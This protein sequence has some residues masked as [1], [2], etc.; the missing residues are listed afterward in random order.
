MKKDKKG[1]ECKNGYGNC[2]KDD[3][4]IGGS[5]KLIDDIPKY[6][7]NHLKTHQEEL[8]KVL[9]MSPQEIHTIKTI[10]R[11]LLGEKTILGDIKGDL[12]GGSLNKQHLKDLA[13]INNVNDLADMVEEDHK[14]VGGG[15][16]QPSFSHS[17]YQLNE[18][19]GVMNLNKELS[20]GSFLD[21]LGGIG[22]VAGTI[23]PFL[24]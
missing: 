17:N 9:N 1:C 8:K 11:H 10:A 23:L 4:I 12:K 6:E 22:K 19:M 7:D 24:L 20:G 18:D 16:F 5:L 21:T 14:I 3:N 13:E 2:R 15:L